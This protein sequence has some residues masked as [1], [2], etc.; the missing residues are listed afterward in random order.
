MNEL[1]K[2]DFSGDRPAVSDMR[3]GQDYCPTQMTLAQHQ[4]DKSPAR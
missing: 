1:I 4:P 2:V 3:V